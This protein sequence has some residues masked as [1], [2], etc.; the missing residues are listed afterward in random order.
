MDERVRQQTT[1]EFLAIKFPHLRKS[2]LQKINWRLGWLKQ[3]NGGH[4]EMVTRF[5]NGQDRWT[6]WNERDVSDP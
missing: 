3:F 4:G 2:W 5:S 1:D 6:G